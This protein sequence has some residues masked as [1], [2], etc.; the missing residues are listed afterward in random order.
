MTLEG[1]LALFAVAAY[2]VWVTV[3]RRNWKGRALEAEKKLGRR[4]KDL[5][6]RGE[7]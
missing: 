7:D 3:S 4:L 6:I 1:C 5:R 2:V